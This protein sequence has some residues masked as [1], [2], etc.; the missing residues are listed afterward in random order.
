[1]AG[2]EL[3][4]KRLKRVVVVAIDQ[5]DF[6]GCILEPLRGS[7]SGEASTENDRAGQRELKTRPSAAI[8]EPTSR[9]VA[10]DH[11]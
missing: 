9:G 7:D 8:G 2:R 6:G 10:D 4:E 5:H 3:V 1:V 11:E